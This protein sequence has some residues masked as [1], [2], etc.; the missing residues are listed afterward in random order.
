MLAGASPIAN[1]ARLFEYMM[2]R[3]RLNAPISRR[4]FEQATCMKW[5][6]LSQAANDGLQRGLLTSDADQLT[7]TELGRRHLDEVVSGFLP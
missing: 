6:Q 7:L 5:A 4:E 3:L 2:T 1:D